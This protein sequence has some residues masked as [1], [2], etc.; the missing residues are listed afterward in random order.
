MNWIAN[1]YSIRHIRPIMITSHLQTLRNSWV[2]RD[3]AST[4]KLLIKQMSTL[5]KISIV[6]NLIF[7]L[8]R[9]VPLIASSL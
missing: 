1:W 7:V 8:Q 6:E 2:A 5:L 9:K 3:L 4:I